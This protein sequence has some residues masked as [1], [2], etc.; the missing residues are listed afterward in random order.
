MGTFPLL[1]GWS[2]GNVCRTDPTMDRGL[3]DGRWSLP[4]P[5]DSVE[6]SCRGP[7]IC[8][9]DSK[10]G[11]DVYLQLQLLGSPHGSLCLENSFIGDI[12]IASKNH[13][14]YFCHIS[15]SLRMYMDG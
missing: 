4:L 2:S 11:C 12:R 10:H 8:T 15:G 6:A 14:I 3:A 7:F 9:A 5:W 1:S 13:S